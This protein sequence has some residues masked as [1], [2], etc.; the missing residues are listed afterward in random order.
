MNSTTKKTTTASTVVSTNGNNAGP[1]DTEDT[2]ELVQV[3]FAAL[4]SD[5]PITVQ[6]VHQML[7]VGNHTEEEIDECLE[8]LQEMKSSVRTWGATNIRAKMAEIA[9]KLPTNDLTLALEY[10]NNPVTNF[11]DIKKWWQLPE[12]QSDDRARNSMYYICYGYFEESPEWEIFLE[13]Q[14]MAAHKWVY[15]QQSKDSIQSKN[16]RKG[17]QIKGCVARNLA[18]VKHELVKQLQKAGREH[19]SFHRFTK[20]RTK[21]DNV[22][23]ESKRRKK[24][25][26]YYKSTMSPVKKN[27]AASQQQTNTMVTMFLPNNMVLIY[28]AVLTIYSFFHCFAKLFRR[29]PIKKHLWMQRKEL[30]NQLTSSKS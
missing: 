24:G 20:S 22:Q 9:R 13:T 5:V 16:R 11:G 4:P 21:D 23:L 17:Y 2:N 12:V 18:N 1:G 25:E 19:N 14:C 26:F 15:T 6:H 30:L 8:K 29:K 28:E 27:E 3:H 10:N 7:G